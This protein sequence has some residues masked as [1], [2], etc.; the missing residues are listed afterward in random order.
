MANPNLKIR[1]GAVDR[2]GNAFRSINT[3]LRRVKHAVFSVQ[4]AVA[5]LAGATGFGLLVKGTIETNREFQSLEASLSTFL[6]ST[7]KAEKAFGILQQFAATTPFALREVVGGFNKLIARG[8][9]PSISALTAFGNIASGTGKTLDQFVEAAA[10]AAVGEFERLKEFGIK[11]RSEGDKVVFTFKGVETEV[12]KSGAAISDFL[13]N[14]GETEFAGAIEKQS[15][16]LNGAFSN[17]GDSFDMFKRTI[18][19]AGFN[20]ALVN[21]ARNFS[22]IAKNNDGLAQSIGRFLA[23]GVNAIPTIFGAVS[24]AADIVRRNL[25]FLR[26]SFIAV[27]AFVFTRAILGQAVAFLRLAGALLTARKAATIYSATSKVLTLS[28][29]ATAIVFAKLTGQLDKMV[30][31]IESAVRQATDLLEK[32]FPGLRGELDKLFPSLNKDIKALEELKNANDLTITSTEELDRQLTEL[33]GTMDAGPKK[34]GAFAEAMK[35]LAADARNMESQFANF[36]TRGLQSLEDNLVSVAMQTKSTKEA[37][38]D[39]ARSI[40]ADLI[41]IEIRRSIT[42]PLAEMIPTFFG[43]ADG[44][45]AMGGP[46]TAGRPYLVGERGPELFVPGRTGGIVPN[47]QM[48]GGGVTVNQTINLTTGV[49]QTVRAE[50]L[51]MLPQIAEAAKGAVLDAKR[52]GGSYAAAMG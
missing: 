47:N 51:N 37:F 33:V 20:D 13:V 25:D 28:T 6:G 4:T 15:Q 32:T 12:T 36:A 9:N 21:L 41:R 40:I 42:A 14:L 22:E 35:K 8:L 50:V 18:G 30:E 52:R 5:A 24:D 16:T 3:G 34:A 23:G 17:L 38:R 29:L 46:V 45:K 1:I 31:G 44:A 43:K 48:G 27:T 11:A 26:K 10:D 2:T 7:E 19:E 39:M 49:S